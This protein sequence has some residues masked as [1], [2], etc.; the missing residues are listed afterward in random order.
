[1]RPRPRFTCKRCAGTGAL[2]TMVVNGVDRTGTIVGGGG[3]G[4]KTTRDRRRNCSMRTAAPSRGQREPKGGVNRIDRLPNAASMKRAREGQA[5]SN[6][7][8]GWHGLRTDDGR[9][10]RLVA[11]GLQVNR[12]TMSGTAFWVSADYVGCGARYPVAFELRRDIRL[13]AAVERRATVVIG[14]GSQTGA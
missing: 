7:K 1:M 13:T 9:R 8:G 10:A 3:R 12:A 5:T 4:R 11:D 2:V 6:R 14:N